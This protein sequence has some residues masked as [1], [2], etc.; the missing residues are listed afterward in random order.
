MN[1][2]A[3]PSVVV[4]SLKA[5]VAVVPQRT[6][7]GFRH[8]AVTPSSI[9]QRQLSGHVFQQVSHHALP[10]FPQSETRN[11]QN[12]PMSIRTMTTGQERRKR[13]P[14][15]TGFN[16]GSMMRVAI[17]NNMS[18]YGPIPI[19]QALRSDTEIS[20]LPFVLL[21]VASDLHPPFAARISILAWLRTASW[22]S[23]RHKDA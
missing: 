15:P 21:S 4:T 13:M 2:K 22:S 6:N 3:V 16:V 11:L 19:R 23:C 9:N 20:F 7:D 1:R 12:T 10:G 5:P 17:S 18:R 8:L 14:M